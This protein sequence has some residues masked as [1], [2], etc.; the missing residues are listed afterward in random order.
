MEAAHA[1]DQAAGLAQRFEDHLI[2]SR[3]L[4]Q[5]TSVT[6]AL[7]GGLDSVVLLHLMMQIE[8]KRDFRLSAAHFDHRMRQGSES[9]A[10]WVVALCESLGVP[11]EIGRSSRVPRSEADARELRYQFLLAARE[12]LSSEYLATAHQADDQA[13]TV[14]FRLLRG[15]GV[16]GLAGIPARRDPCIAR[17]LLPF[18]REELAAYAERRRL[19]FLADPTNADIRYS[20]NR[21]RHLLIPALEADEGP[22]LRRQLYRLSQ[23]ARRAS[24]VIEGATERAAQRLILESTEARV[25]VARKQMLAYD[26]NACAHLLR[27]L[28]ARVG[29]RPGRA[30]TLSALEFIRKCSSGRRIE[31]TGGVELRREF[32][33]FIIERGEANSGSDGTLQL[34]D[35][36]AGQEVVIIGG[37]S[38]RVSWGTEPVAFAPADAQVASFARGELEGPLSVRGWRP[39]DRI[40]MPGGTRKLKKL[41]GDRKVG[42]SQRPRTPLLVDRAGVLWVVGVARSARAV[43]Q[44]DEPRLT[45]RI[46]RDG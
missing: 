8:E 41:F 35:V 17:P 1:P 30:G 44:R 18:W 23:L 33:R 22:G 15:T 3:L 46:R 36:V 29:P 10:R 31:L 42:L 11:L 38:W 19:R 6:L 16:R 24:V 13:E 20:R 2:S 9:D 40:R 5:G 26:T 27:H 25:V 37:H 43:P 4:P 45:L 7:S 12:R 28:V 21:I 34:P 32:D 14:L 39:G